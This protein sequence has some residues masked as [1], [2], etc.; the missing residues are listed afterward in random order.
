[1][2][3]IP[4]SLD[5]VAKAASPGNGALLGGRLPREAVPCNH[6]DD[7]ATSRSRAAGKGRRRGTSQRLR[8][9]VAILGLV[10]V[11]T[12]TARAQQTQ[13]VIT[14]DRVAVRGFVGIYDTPEMAHL[15]PPNAEN[16]P[17]AQ[18]VP[19]P[20]EPV[21]ELPKP[22]PVLPLA[23]APGEGTN[24]PSFV[25]EGFLVEAFW[26]VRLGS[27][28]ARFKRAHF[29]PPDLSSGFEAQHLGNPDELHGIYIRSLDGRPFGLN[30]LRY[31][32]TRNRQLPRKPFSIEG[33]SNYN[34]N[35]LI[36]RSFDPRR[37]IRGQFLSFP[38]GLPTGNDPTL[39]WWTL[40][41][42]GFDQV[43]QVFIASSASVD[44]D[45]IVLTRTAEK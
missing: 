30:R 42:S 35:V 15:N 8:W 16:A 36:A 11:G 13:Y 40:P 24:N 10:L 33:F 45:D 17:R 18:P 26:V 31:R 43:E 34:V 7:M 14:F 29:H 27:P 6:R 19:R 2:F 23:L 4:R 38:V 41:V 22:L 1:M 5:L 12:S 20:G 9:A 28:S 37:A 21:A 3:R 25:Q 32:V 44:L 39:P